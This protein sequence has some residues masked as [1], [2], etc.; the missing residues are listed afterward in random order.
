ML[1][2]LLSS[3]CI[4]VILTILGPGGAVAVTWHV[5]V[6]ALTIQAG[7]D[8]AS[9]G[10]TVE[11]A[12]GTYPEHG[13]VMKSGVCLR[14]ETG[15]ADCVVI[16]GEGASRVFFC[17]GVDASTRIEGF[18]ITNGRS[19]TGGGMYCYNPTLHIANCVFADD[20]AGVGGGIY[21]LANGDPT[22]TNCLFW[23]NR[24]ADGGA[25]YADVLADPEFTQCT[26]VENE[27][28]NNAGAVYAAGTATV[29]MDNSIVAFNTSSGVD[30]E[31]YCTAGGVTLSCCN[32]FGNTAGDYEGCIAGQDLIN[33]NFSADPVFCY[34]DD[35]N[36]YLHASS[37]CLSAPGCGQVGAYGQ[38]CAPRTW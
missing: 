7:I 1:R 22:L 14:S 31:I 29:E 37:P 34:P 38:G 2:T 4:C 9:A 35:G 24:A 15:E 21:C 30:G 5:P 8:S 32:V 17:D 12:C 26:F 6:D 18:T 3:T 10:D 23:N 16:D 20:S 36:F 11:V 28:S 33:D 27:A 19:N 25:V 13:L